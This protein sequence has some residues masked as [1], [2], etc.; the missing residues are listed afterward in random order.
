MIHERCFLEGFAWFESHL[1]SSSL[2][3]NA[4]DFG[5]VRFDQVCAVYQFRAIGIGTSGEYAWRSI[6]MTLRRGE[7]E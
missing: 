2:D 7:M 5:Q 4:V 1:S 6:P 3:Q